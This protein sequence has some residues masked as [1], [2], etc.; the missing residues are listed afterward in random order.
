[1]PPK[2]GLERAPPGSAVFFGNSTPRQVQAAATGMA[3]DTV[4]PATLSPAAQQTADDSDSAAGERHII[5]APTTPADDKRRPC[6]FLRC[7]M[8]VFVA[9]HCVV[10]LAQ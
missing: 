4:A 1:M 9:S 8:E 3:L 10:W 7:Q 6:S 2:A 5:S